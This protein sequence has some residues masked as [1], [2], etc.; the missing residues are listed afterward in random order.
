M[1]L[2]IGANN[3]F[4]TSKI[5]AQAIDTQAVKDIT[6][7]ILNT[8]A[9]TKSVD[10]DSLNL[11]KFNRVDLGVDLYSKQTSAQ[12][13]TQ[14]AA[15]NADLDVNMNSQKFIN[16][17]QYLNSLAAVNAH[18][19]TKQAD[20]KFVVPQTTDNQVNMREVFALPKAAELF[21]SQNLSKD[22]RGSNPFSYQAPSTGNDDSKKADSL[23]IFA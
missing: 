22:K 23:S 14:I 4:T 15:R 19:A 11:S 17:I 16:S 13:A 9:E 5:N 1:S 7:Q 21:E 10:L 6:T 3:F 2:N 8:P 20:G 12:E 18:Q